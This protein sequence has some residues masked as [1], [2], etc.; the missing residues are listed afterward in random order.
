[1]VKHPHVVDTEVATLL[2]GSE[3]ALRPLNSDDVGAVVNLH[4]QLTDREK[5][6]RF[7]VSHPKHLAQFAQRLVEC[8][9]RQ[10]ALGAFESGQLIGVTSY[11]V[12][13]ESDT[14]EVAIA[15]AHEDH[16][17][18]VGTVLLRALGRTALNDGIRY[19]VADVLVQ[20][21]GMRRVIADAGW[22]HTT[23]YNGSVLSI[24]IDLTAIIDP[25]MRGSVNAL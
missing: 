10:R 11:F 21:V 19:F 7:F 3:V 2:D 20:N 13:D 5:Y 12:T 22:R 9:K 15:V 8:N 18:G 23:E 17:R 4:Q 24:R 16:L 1:M 6:M 25:Y 14:A